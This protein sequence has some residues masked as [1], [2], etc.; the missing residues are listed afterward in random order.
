MAVR[1]VRG[2]SLLVLFLSFLSGSL[3][4]QAQ[5]A[6]TPPS[7][8]RVFIDCQY[9]CDTTYLRENITFIEYVRDRATSDLHLLVTTQ[10][11]GGGG[12][13]WN[14][15]FIGLDYFMGQDRNLAFNTPQ[16]A[17]SD[18]RRKEFAR[19][20]KLGL[21]GYVAE[22]SVASD[23]EIGFR[24]QSESEERKAAKP[25]RDPWNFWV[26]RVGM[27]GN[28]SGEQSSN[29]R[30]YRFNGSAGRTTEN[31]KL[32]FFANSNT[33]NSTFKLDN[34]TTIKSSNDGWNVG[35]LIVKSLGPKWS[36]G[37]RTN[38]SHSSFSN[39]DRS[40]G[41]HPAIEFDFFPYSVSTRRSLTVQ[42]AIGMTNYQYR[43]LTIFDKLKETV[44]SHTV[45]T[46]LGIRAPWG[47]VGGGVNISEHLNHM[48]RYRIGM[49]GNTN[50]RLFKGF[51]FDMYAN[52]DK[53][54]DQIGLAKGN[55][56]E[57]EVLLQLRQRATGY[58]YYMGFGVNYSFGSIF[59]STVNPRFGGGGCC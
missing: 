51:S 56:S 22:T 5:A 49:Y 45:S 2:A 46:S 29:S 9:E 33:N 30:S 14:L 16:T 40:F 13:A 15:K 53:I 8:L 20:F 47:N 39:T 41:A 52:Y 24:K 21:V 57:A 1:L 27:N 12:M 26:F 35:S 59:N 6:K 54:N 18:D 7:R 44:P 50:V 25:V 37:A 34:N 43:E 11:T 55:I 28:L 58:S 48:D 36:Y 31:W 4:A 32:N 10:E 23:L 19:V 3:N 38:L 42:Y 17:S